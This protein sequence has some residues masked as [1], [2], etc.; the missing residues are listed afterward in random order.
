ME[1]GKIEDLV[2]K[3]F[4]GET[5]IAEENALHAYFS[6][7]NVSKH[8]EQYKTIFGY[9]SLAKED[10]FKPQISLPP[11]P[12]DKKSI[13]AWISIAA[14][15]VVLLGIG[16]YAFYTSNVANKSRDLGTYDDPE[17]AFR[18]TQKAL[19]LLSGNVN[20]GIESFQYIKEYQT[21]KDKIFIN[22]KKQTG[23]S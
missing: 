2:E 14:S 5:S 10:Q 6:S 13:V 19:L 12:R 18:A 9:F 20:I 4:Q 22:P 16:S 21:T 1:S 7:S 8:L 3:Y 15:I 11:N 17:E 23:G